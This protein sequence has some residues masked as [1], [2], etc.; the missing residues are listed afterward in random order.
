MRMFAANIYELKFW[1]RQ[2]LSPVNRGPQCRTLSLAYKDI[3]LADPMPPHSGGVA[4]FLPS[5]KRIS[6][7]E[8]DDSKG[9]FILL[10]NIAGIISGSPALGALMCD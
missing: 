9:T 3:L 5:H 10:M 4:R 2:S 1:R 8:D 6:V 7:L